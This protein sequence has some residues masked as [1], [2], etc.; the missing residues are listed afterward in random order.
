VLGT[1]VRGPRVA[2]AEAMTPQQTARR[3][4]AANNYLTLATADHDGRPWAAP[5]Y[6]TADDGR[7]L[8]WV[9]RPDSRH[10]RNVTARP[11]VGIVIYNSQVP[12][13]AAEA[14]YLRATAEPVHDTDLERCARIFRAR[15]AELASFTS[16]RLRT[17]HPLRL[18]RAHIVEASV[19]VDDGG[20]DIR[21]SITVPV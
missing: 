9:S 11:E 21:Q 5:V 6:Y 2:D 19:L 10:S 12:L 8:Y 20:P 7:D 17:P 13:G 4:V 18:Y 14:V 15:H 16:E 1:D 3:I